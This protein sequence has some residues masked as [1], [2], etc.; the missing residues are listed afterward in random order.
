[1]STLFATGKFALGICD[2]CGQQYKYLEL[3]KEWTGLKVCPECYEVKAPQLEPFVP[4]PDLQALFEPR[5]ARKAP[6]VVPVGAGKIFPR[7]SAAQGLAGLTSVG[8]VA[9][10]IS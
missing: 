1:M 9:V 3:R 10:V 4:P 2:R 5:T 6:V 7:P 8:V